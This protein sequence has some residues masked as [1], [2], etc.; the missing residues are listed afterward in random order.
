MKYS[1]FCCLV[2]L[3]LSINSQSKTISSMTLSPHLTEL[4]Y[5]AGGGN[6]LVGVSAY[7]NYPE[8]VKKLPMIGDAFRLDLEQI[9]TLNPDVIFYWKNGT[10]NQVI[11]QLS[12]LEFNLHEITINH[13]KDIPNAINEIASILGTTPLE[14]TELFQQ[15][16]SKLKR[17]IQ[18][19]TA[20]IQISSKPIYTVNGKH[21]MSE[22]L[23]VCGL[24][25]IFQDLE[26]LS[27][28]VTLESVVLK[29][30]EYIITTGA[31]AD[32]P[33]LEWSSIPAINKQQIITLNPDTFSRPTLRLLESI[34]QLCNQVKN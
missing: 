20:L 1:L 5:S 18:N 29:K 27:A 3:F 15:K 34:E 8:E 12:S 11:Q 10:A 28:A 16:L 22:A 24:K 21:W 25:N 6:T 26:L 17:E 7:S 2:G 32:N 23:E 14:P 30:P 9:K 19:H 13:L 4:V 31:M 33:L